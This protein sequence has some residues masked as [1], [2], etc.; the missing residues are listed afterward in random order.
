M[1][2][3]RLLG[4]LAPVL[5]LAVA[6]EDSSS[7]SG[8]VFNPEAGPGFDGGG[9]PEAGPIPVADAG[10]DAPPPTPKGVTVTVL[11]A[12]V[13]KKDV[14][15]IFHDAT[16]A[17]T[18]EK[19]T[20]A[21]GKASIAPAPSAITVLAQRTSA[22]PT[23]VTY[24][25]V[26]EG[27][28]LIV[29]L[30]EIAT[31][32]PA[33]GQY[34][35]SFTQGGLLTGANSTN[36]VVGGGC[37]GGTQ[38]PTQPTAVGL[39]PYC[40]AAK[41]AVLGSASAN[42]TLLGFGFAKDVAKPALNATAPVGPLTPLKAPGQTNVT[43]TNA[44]DINPFAELYAIANGQ[45]FFAQGGGGATTGAG[46]K[47]ITATDFA[48]AYQ[49]VVRGSAQNAFSSEVGFIRREATTAP[50]SLTL[51]FDF[52]NA[53]PKVT[54]VTTAS[55]TVGRPDVTLTS[56]ASL[57]T[58]DGGA[59]TLRW[60]TATNNG[61]SWTFVLPGPAAAASFKAPAL[62]ADATVFVPTRSVFVDGAVFFEA[63]QIPSYTETK[64][65]P[66]VAGGGLDL[67]DWTRPLPVNG[68]VRLTSWRQPA[69]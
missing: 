9:L 68:T 66:I 32:G 4:L 50:D 47:F 36:V 53:L 17:V 51:G 42:G 37:S 61:G 16:G 63:T 40:V 14:R 60:T 8:G 54:D 10:I 28:N 33:I 18:G 25:G 45:M 20:D 34:S 38:D 52:A 48:D 3:L 65:L 30:P 21:T 11:D 58:S 7:S 27:D 59:V 67:L 31:E 26:A 22:V 1:R 23:N 24:F 13:G 44:N 56:A 5:L 39:F 62:P 69:L 57:A 15:V 43:V 49:T 41:N 64:K 2:N 35:V 6:C 46:A 29:A 12:L 55:P 19:L